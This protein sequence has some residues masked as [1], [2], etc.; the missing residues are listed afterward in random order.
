MVPGGD[1]EDRDRR[2]SSSLRER[3]YH[4][5][6]R[7]L[8]KI[9]LIVLGIRWFLRWR[10]RRRAEAELETAPASSSDPAG[11]L[12]QKLA[13]SRVEEAVDDVPEAPPEASVGDRRAD[14]H[15]QGRATVDEMKSSGEG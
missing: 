1:A 12:R 11:E 13:A 8:I 5:A 14:V 15:E 7:K 10:K 3:R 2:S 9:A 6:V 4:R